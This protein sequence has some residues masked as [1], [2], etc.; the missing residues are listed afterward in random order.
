MARL[1]GPIAVQAVFDRLPGL[2]LVAAP[3]PRGFAFRR[4]PKLDLSWQA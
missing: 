3:E 2:A 4:S 1:Q